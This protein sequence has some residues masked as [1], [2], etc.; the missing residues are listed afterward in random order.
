MGL[1]VTKTVSPQAFGDR[2]LAIC[3]VAWDTSYASGGEAL[4]P[5]DLGFADQA[6]SDDF[7]VFSAVFEGVVAEY[8]YANE[9]LKLLQGDYS[10]S[11]DGPFVEV[12]GDVS[13][14]EALPLLVFGKFR[15]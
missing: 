9:K 14:V 4:T 3:H 15:A 10:N 7:V 1:T 8:D 12:S 13:S 2:Y 6:T 5:A 11:S